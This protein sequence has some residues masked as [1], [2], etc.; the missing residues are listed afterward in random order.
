V[1]PPADSRGCLRLRDEEEDADQLKDAAAER[2]GQRAANLLADRQ[3]AA[4]VL[5]QEPAELRAGDERRRDGREGQARKAQGRILLRHLDDLPLGAY[6]NLS[7]PPEPSFNSA[8]QPL[9]EQ[10]PCQDGTDAG[11]VGAFACFYL[12]TSGLRVSTVP[13]GISGESA[14]WSERCYPRKP[15][16]D[17]TRHE[18]RFGRVRIASTFR[19]CTHN[20]QST[21]VLRMLASVTIAGDCPDLGHLAGMRTRQCHGRSPNKVMTHCGNTGR[22]DVEAVRWSAY[23]YRPAARAP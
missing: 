7:H 2:R 20:T 3:E 1:S 10:G 6:R 5:V 19:N 9:M 13:G 15:G 14:S 11:R 8:S 17:S 16:S 18:C 12:C 4:H 21:R 23:A 22:E